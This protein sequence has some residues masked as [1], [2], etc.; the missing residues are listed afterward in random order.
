MTKP[1]FAPLSI[2]QQVA[3]LMLLSGILG[4]G[5]MS[6]SLWM[7]QGMQGN[8][9]AINKAGSLRM[10]SY[11]L[12]SRV[13]LDRDS[14]PLI[15][16]LER[17]QLSDDLQQPVKRER[18]TP[19][20]LA[21]RAHWHTTLK[22]LLLRAQRPA[23]AAGGVAEFVRRL[24]AL[25]SDLD[26]NTE[27]RLT[28]VA[29]VQKIVIALTLLV[30]A[31]T[32]IY[33]RR[34]LLRP[35][36][37]LLNQA[38][39]VSRGDF[40]QRYPLPA[41]AR[42]GGHHEMDQLGLTLNGMSQSLSQIYAEL[43]QR[44]ADK[45]A[46]L[47]QKNRALDFLYRASRQLHTGEPLPGRLH[48]VLEELQILTPLREIQIRL[49]ENDHDAGITETA[50]VV[51]AAVVPVGDE[52]EQLSWSLHDKLGQYGIMLA[53]YPARHIMD[54]A[55]RRLVATL[56]EQLTSTLALER[57]AEHQQQLLLMAERTAIA[58]E[59]HDSIAQSLS[60]LKLQIGV[61][62][63]Q[64][65]DTTP[66]NQLLMQQM[67]DELNTAYR[68]LRELLTTFRLRQT[69]PGLRAALQTTV[70]EFSARLGFA[71]DFTYRL[72]AKTVSSHQ[73]IHLTQIARE[74]L[75]NIVKHAGASRVAVAARLEADG[76]VL[77]IRDNGRGLPDEHQRQHHYGLVIMQDRARSLQGHCRV[78]RLACG[79]TEV[80]VYVPRQPAPTH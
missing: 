7:A 9:H 66:E 37:R 4:V 46:D 35:W 21:L 19:Q 2:V 47:R 11:R 34:R 30:L 73:V 48:T 49:Y 50:G 33:L 36:R 78:A 1:L 26:R 41:G 44:V 76:L 45:T 23:D 3:L 17:D 80:R 51:P 61:L 22:P 56:I 25:V 55:Q 57:Q 28:L 31:G 71:I 74:A 75:T 24:D 10:Q 43:E 77:D 64:S 65:A 14:G 58:G 62:Q 67:R 60:C 53:Q 52:A 5:G 72:P 8:A 32:I 69:E 79:G 42:R 20:Y 54:D 27:R 18:L 16:E 40:S 29:S 6:L 39:A 68:Q 12:L 13:P 70:E 59:L 63:M 15:A 38:R